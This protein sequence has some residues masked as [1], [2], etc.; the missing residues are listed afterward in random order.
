M[1]EISSTQCLI[2]YNLFYYAVLN[3]CYIILKRLDGYPNQ[4]V[5]LPQATNWSIKKVDKRGVSSG[6]AHKL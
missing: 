1:C 2:S 6:K 4:N 3:Q 5:A